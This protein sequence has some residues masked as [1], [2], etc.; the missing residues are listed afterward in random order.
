MA[1]I[2]RLI[3]DNLE[4]DVA[5]QKFR[6]HVGNTFAEIVDDAQ[7]ASADL[8]VHGNVDLSLAVDAHDVGLDEAGVFRRGDVAEIGGVARLRA[9]RNVAHALDQVDHGVG[10]NGVVDGADAGVA[11]GQEQVVL[12]D[13]AHDVDGGQLAGLKLD[14]VEI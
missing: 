13:G 6:L 2:D 11:R 7:G 14:R 5:L 1:H 12:V 9:Q 3:H 10:A 4:L 8:P